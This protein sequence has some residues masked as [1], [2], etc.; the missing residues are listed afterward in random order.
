MRE[1]RLDSQL[2]AFDDRRVTAFTLGEAGAVTRFE[3]I[4]GAG[5]SRCLPRI[6][7]PRRRSIPFRRAAPRDRGPRDRP[8]GRRARAVRPGAAAPCAEVRGRGA[9]RD[10]PGRRR[11]H[12]SR[13]LHPRVG[14]PRRP[15]RQASRAIPLADLTTAGLRD[16]RL[17]SVPRSQVGAIAIAR[18]GPSSGSCVATAAGGSRRRGVPGLGRRG[19]ADPRDPRGLGVGAPRRPS[20][21]RRSRARPVGARGDGD[22]AERGVGGASR[23]LG[24]VGPDGA[25]WATRDDRVA[26]MRFPEAKFPRLPV[27]FEEL[28][29]TKLTKVNRYAV[30]KLAWRGS[31]RGGRRPARGGDDVEGPFGRIARRG[32]GHRV[33]RR[34]AG[35][36]GV[37]LVGGPSFGRA[38]GG[39]RGRG[40]RRRS[41][42]RRVLRRR[43]RPGRLA[44]RRSVSPRRGAADVPAVIGF[45]KYA[46]T[47][48]V[49]A[50]SSLPK[51]CSSRR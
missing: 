21:S 41:G 25:A 6:P 1:A 13:A 51:N 50:E 24:P 22:P 2:V 8:R 46:A 4:E 16:R 39:A 31:R 12:R 45:Q 42:A 18:G 36:A 17:L 23:R 15:P 28:R 7:P 20:R 10:R 14:P 34:G 29:E 48:T 5:A 32:V 3:R 43:D 9:P 40:R 27:A 33:P 35:S 44:S 37:E 19:R 26:A 38:G 49:N 30:T 47:P 11:S